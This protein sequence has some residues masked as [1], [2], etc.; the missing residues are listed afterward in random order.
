MVSVRYSVL[1]MNSIC[2]YTNFA[3]CLSC[4]SLRSLPTVSQEGW[5]EER[6]ELKESSKFAQYCNH[7]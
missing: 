4:S 3:A 1:F 2:V 7:K 5:E 6:A